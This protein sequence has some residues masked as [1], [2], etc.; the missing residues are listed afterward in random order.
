MVSPLIAAAVVEGGLVQAQTY[1]IPAHLL[2]VPS[3]TKLSPA[4]GDVCCEQA[5]PER[6]GELSFLGESF[7]Q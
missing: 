2:Q 6:V 3:L 7:H 4:Q 5:Q 1:L